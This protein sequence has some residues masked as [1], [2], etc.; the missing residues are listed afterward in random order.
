MQ[1]CRVIF[2]G[3]ASMQDPVE[4]SVSNRQPSSSEAPSSTLLPQELPRTNKELA[5][6]LRMR[7]SS[8]LT[9]LSRNKSSQYKVLKIPKGSKFRTVYNPSEVMRIAQ[10]RILREVLEPLFEIPEYIYAFERDK[11]IPLM[12]KVHEGSHMVVSMDIKD[13]FPSIRQ[14]K[15]YELMV[16]RG[17]AESPSRTL[18]ELMTLGPNVPQGGLTSPKISNIIAAKTFGPEVK[19]YCDERGLAL[20]IYA[21]DVTISAQE[22]FNA[23]EAISFIENSLKSHGFRVNRK[24]TKVMRKGTRRS[25]LYVCG[26]VVNEKVNLLK[27]DRL[28]LRAIV[29]NSEVNG[30]PAEAAKTELTPNEF[31]QRI[32]GKLN[33]FGQLNERG[34]ARLI[35][36]FRNVCSGWEESTRTSPYQYQG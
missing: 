19:Q 7:N 10:Y 12:A 26:T 2:T 13:Y 20:T 5:R 17:F 11:S 30:I 8:L 21:D 24:K 31:I 35:E 33:W 22:P 9:W 36:Q 18:S 32:R 16:E 15:V 25:R 14:S 3:D 34:A 29:H 6:M 28:K 4:N 1:S 23:Q 27:Q